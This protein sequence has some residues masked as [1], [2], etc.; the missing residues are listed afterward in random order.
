M[1]IA[2]PQLHVNRVPAKSVL[3]MRSQP[4]LSVHWFDSAVSAAAIGCIQLLLIV[5]PACAHSNARCAALLLPTCGPRVQGYAR[6]PFTTA[7]AAACNNC[8][9]MHQAEL[10]H[11]GCSATNVDS[12]C[13]AQTSAGMLVPLYAE[14]EDFSSWRRVIAAAAQLPQ[15]LVVVV[16]PQSGRIGG[17]GQFPMEGTGR[18]L[19]WENL[20]RTLDAAGVMVVGYVSTCDSAVDVNNCPREKQG[21]RS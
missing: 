14:P 2:V 11:A 17:R 5:A 7:A 21:R 4:R 8:C 16:N 20:T 15:S 1:R 3:A 18:S 10:R 9:G 13:A 19:A 6:A 12:I